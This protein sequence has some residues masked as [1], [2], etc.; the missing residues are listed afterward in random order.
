MSTPS[1][2]LNADTIRSVLERTLL[3]H[4]QFARKIGVS[5]SHWSL[6]FNGHHPLTKGMRRRLLACPLLSPVKD[7]L[8]RPVSTEDTPCAR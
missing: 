3:T 7:D 6:L 4:E 1:L 2:F 5:R 8:W